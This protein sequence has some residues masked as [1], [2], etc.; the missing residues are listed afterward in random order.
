[1]CP[2]VL[3][4]ALR[5]AGAT[6]V[7]E[8]LREKETGE[9]ITKADLMEWGLVGLPDS[10]KKRGALLERLGLPAHMTPNALLPVLNALYTKE[11]FREEL[12]LP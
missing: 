8:Q 4:G 10:G 5:R 6:F 7:E 1:M 3:E 9:P 12:S 2:A 11:T